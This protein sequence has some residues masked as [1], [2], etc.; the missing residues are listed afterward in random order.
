MLTRVMSLP[1]VHEVVSF[2]P[3]DLNKPAEANDTSRVATTVYRSTHAGGNP[4]EA[5][6][7]VTGPDLC[8]MRVGGRQ[9]RRVN[10]VAR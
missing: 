5:M 4:P 9:R 10:S 8:D 2:A 7:F 3:Q 6:V 1:N